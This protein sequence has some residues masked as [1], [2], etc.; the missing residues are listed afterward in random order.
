[1]RA[2][3]AGYD[4]PDGKVLAPM[5][6]TQAL[7]RRELVRDKSAHVGQTFG[8]TM[9]STITGAGR[10]EVLRRRAAALDA[11]LNPQP[12]PEP[13][14]AP[15]PPPGWADFEQCPRPRCQAP[16]GQSCID[17]RG[18]LTPDG[19]PAPVA[20]AHPGRRLLSPRAS[21]RAS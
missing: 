8:D 2:L 9:T 5:G 3:D 14:P 12:D 15:L 10:A 11:E 6:T 18:A 16:T 20:K 7:L 13:E 1:V 4:H 17:L 19:Q 21:R